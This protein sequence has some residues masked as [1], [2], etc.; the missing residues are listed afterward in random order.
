MNERPEAGNAVE[1]T[2]GIRRILAP[3]AS[4]MTHWGTNTY[5]LG[6]DEVV[7]IDPGPTSDAHLVALKAAIGGAPVSH[8]LITHAHLDHSPL[9]RA[10]DAPVLAFGAATEGRRPTM[11]QLAELG[12]V[13]GGEG[14]DSAFAPDQYIADGEILQTGA[15]DIE[16]I[17]TPGH[18]SGHLSFAIGDL[19]FTGD[20]VMGWASTL[21]SPPDGDL[22][23][24]RASCERL[25]RRHDRAYLPGHGGAID[26]PAERLSWLIAHRNA[27]EAEILKALESGPTP[28]SAITRRVYTDIPPKMLPMAERNVLAHLIDLEEQNKATKDS[29]SH[30]EALWSRSD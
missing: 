14:V 5:L 7:L 18:M 10:F 1:V 25:A 30:L 26:A 20:H 8:V 4:P 19:V 9:A 28:I 21:I 2:P 23:S 3:N 22:A 16:V 12:S 17:H 15:G 6:V 27:R 13:G 11:Q 24:F 29:R